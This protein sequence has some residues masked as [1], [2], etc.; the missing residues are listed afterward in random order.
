MKGT[1]QRRQ[2]SKVKLET[3]KKEY[4]GQRVALSE[5]GS[6]SDVG[7]FRRSDVSGLHEAKNNGFRNW[8]KQRQRVSE[9][10]GAKA[11]AEM[12]RIA[13]SKGGGKRTAAER[14]EQKRQE[15]KHGKRDKEEGRRKKE[16]QS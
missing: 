8:A 9:W 4:S 1:E 6:A 14:N 16:Q 3:E 11:A 2:L 7:R 5:G 15:Q 12:S 13:W 10:H